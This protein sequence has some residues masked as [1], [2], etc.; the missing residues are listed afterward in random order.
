METIRV[1]ELYTA[2]DKP[3]K[4]LGDYFCDR[5]GD[6]WRL[7]KA[8]ED[9]VVGEVVKDKVAL[10]TGTVTTAAAVGTNRL[11]DTG[12][13]AALTAD[14]LEGASGATLGLLANG[15]GQIFSV[16]KRH[17][18]NEIEVFVK[19]ATTAASVASRVTDGKWAVALTTSSTYELVMHGL[20]EDAIAGV[21][22]SGVCLLAVDASVAPYFYAKVT[23]ECPVLVDDS[24]NN[25]IAGELVTVSP[26]TNG[27]VE[28]PN[29]TVI[30]T[31][32]ELA[33]YVGIAKTG[34]VGFDCLT[35]V[36]LDMRVRARSHVFPRRQHPYSQV[37]V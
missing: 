10:S 35:L 19:W 25:I 34:E 37:T 12:N 23:G 31:A 1:G 20:V 24:D 18:D 30:P 13:F 36:D 16:K 17:S 15:G 8:S 22:P 5:S 3:P 32:T 33:G 2:Y 21:V 29:A 26:S 6:I 11:I 27:H 28:G 9:L 7:V 4:R 14:D